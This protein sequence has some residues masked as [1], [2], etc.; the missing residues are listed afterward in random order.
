VAYIWQPVPTKVDNARCEKRPG[1]GPGPISVSGST[2]DT[3]DDDDNA[4]VIMMHCQV[5][6]GDQDTASCIEGHA[7]LPSSSWTADVRIHCQLCW[8]FT[9]SHTASCPRCSWV[10]YDFSEV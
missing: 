1:P 7:A 8:Q 4:W 3:S 10:R 5:S 9:A 2:I 6:N